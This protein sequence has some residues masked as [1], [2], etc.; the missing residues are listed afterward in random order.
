VTAEALNSD[1]HG[2]LGQEDQDHLAE[3]SRQEGSQQQR[4]QVEDGDVN[5]GEFHG[6]V[7]LSLK[8]CGFAF[9]G[10]SDELLG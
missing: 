6:G 4:D 1:R 8:C 5:A 2:L 9:A 10:L 3:P 7:L